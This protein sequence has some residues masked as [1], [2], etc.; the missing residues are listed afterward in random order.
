LRLHAPDS[1]TLTSFVLRNWEK[2]IEIAS[3][4]ELDDVETF[5]KD[6]RHHARSQDSI[7]S[8]FRG[9]EGLSVGPIRSFVYGSCSIQD[10]DEVIQQ[11]F[12]ETRG[13][14]WEEFFYKINND[15]PIEQ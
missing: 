13:V 9:L 6:L 15:P 10:L 12:D 14:P 5:L 1:F 11:F 2:K 4:H 7:A 8:F 3:K